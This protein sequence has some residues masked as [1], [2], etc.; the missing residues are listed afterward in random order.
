[1]A[2]RTRPFGQGYTVFEWQNQIIG[3]ADQVD[4]T[5]VTP[6][7]EAID[8][9]PINAPRPIEIMTAGAHRHG[10]LT[11]TLLELFNFSIWNRLADLTD[12]QDIIDIMRTIAAM[13]QGIII[14]K[15]VRPP[16]GAEYR[17]QFFNC[18]VV[19]VTDSE[20]IR[21]ETLTVPKTMEIWFTHSLKSW[22]GG[23][24]RKFQSVDI[25][26]QV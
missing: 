19:N 24:K 3:M 9:Q 7:A 20:S 16:N 10:V 14:T 25:A 26:P 1:M 8:I 13:D 15:V 21:I 12:C 18:T 23:G 2:N 6:V 17:E 5:S 22:I 4:V 11:L